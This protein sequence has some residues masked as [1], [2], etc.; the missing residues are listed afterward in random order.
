[1]SS[2]PSPR[3]FC[4]GGRPTGFRSHQRSARTATEQHSRT[5]PATNLTRDRKH[6]TRAP[7]VAA[8]SSGGFRHRIDPGLCELAVKAGKPARVDAEVVL[9]DDVAP[10]CEQ[11]EYGRL[12]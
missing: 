4:S 10:A 12:C 5:T 11:E 7:N 8:A 9:L 2:P 1:M 6:P 3:G